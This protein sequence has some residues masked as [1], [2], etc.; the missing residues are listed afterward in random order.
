MQSKAK[1]VKL[2]QWKME[3]KIGPIY[4]VASEKGLRGVF[5]KKQKIPMAKSKILSR[6]VKQ[7]EEYFKGKR[8]VFDLPLDAK[9][10]EFQELVWTQL[11]K[12]PYGKTFSYSEIAAQI[13]NSKAV[14]AVGTANGKNPL[15]IIVPCHRV[16]SASG[17]L[18]GYSGGLAIKTKL[19]GLEK[20]KPTL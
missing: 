12:I 6:A 5:W 10:T 11:S 19:L 9:G 18:G 20:D 2:V 3:S 8:K 16:I 14:R 1:Q 4:L 15:C 17:S 13:L 7:L